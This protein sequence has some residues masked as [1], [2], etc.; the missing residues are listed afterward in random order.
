[1]QQSM[2]GAAGEPLWQSDLYGPFREGPRAVPAP[3][4]DLAD[5]ELQLL[6]GS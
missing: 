5:D 1:M 4:P 6:L 3:V 2:P